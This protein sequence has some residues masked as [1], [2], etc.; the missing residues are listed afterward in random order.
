MNLLGSLHPEEGGD[1][2]ADLSSPALLKAER[3]GLAQ[4]PVTGRVGL[5]GGGWLPWAWRELA[6]LP[7]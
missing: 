1:Q 2:A 6:L 5:G 7:Q 4:W 3:G